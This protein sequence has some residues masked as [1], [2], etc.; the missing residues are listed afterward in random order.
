MHF[1][2]LEALTMLVTTDTYH[3]SAFDSCSYQKHAKSS[4]SFGTHNILNRSSRVLQLPAHLSGLTAN[5]F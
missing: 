3:Y 2:W 1:V 5:G 4:V